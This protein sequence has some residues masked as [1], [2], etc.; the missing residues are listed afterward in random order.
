VVVWIA[1][2]QK[3]GDELPKQVGLAISR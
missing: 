3:W 1:V 2:P